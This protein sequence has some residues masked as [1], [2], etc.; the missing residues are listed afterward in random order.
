MRK[1]V[2]FLQER[3]DPDPEHARLLRGLKHLAEAKHF[4]FPLNDFDDFL[5]LK[6][7]LNISYSTLWG[8]SDHLFMDM[9]VTDPCCRS[10]LGEFAEL[11]R[12]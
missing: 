10:L 12:R 7:L 2:V 8:C 6:A 5:A 3:P 11:A 1:C 4:E 9:G